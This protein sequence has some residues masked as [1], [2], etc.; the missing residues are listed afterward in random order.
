M[1]GIIVYSVGNLSDRINLRIKPG[2]IFLKNVEGYGQ[3]GDEGQVHGTLCRLLLGY[4]PS[5]ISDAGGCV[6]GFSVVNGKVRGDSWTC[7]A[8]KVYSDWKNRMMDFE[9]KVVTKAVNMWRE[10]QADGQNIMIPSLITGL[11]ELPLRL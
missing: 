1:G 3:E 6:T 8:G 5:Q 11:H 2:Y 9:K 4:Q 7:N 10:G